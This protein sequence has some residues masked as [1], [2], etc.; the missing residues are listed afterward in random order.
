MTLYAYS[1]PHRMAR[2]WMAAAENAGSRYL[3]VNVRDDDDAFVLSALVPGLKADDLSIQVLEDVV[4]IEGKM[5]DSDGEYLLQELP[6]SRYR[7]ALAAL[8]HLAGIG[9]PVS[10]ADQ[11]HLS[12]LG[13]AHINF[14]GRFNFD[15]PEVVQQGQL[16]PL[17]TPSATDPIRFAF[18]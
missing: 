2:R 1:F 3:A 10:E 12:P 4:R 14:H 6:A 5:A 13:Y 7:D 17:R 11:Q 8:A 15:L 18:T 16:R 9:S